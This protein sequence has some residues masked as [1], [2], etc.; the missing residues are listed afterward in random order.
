MNL[1]LISL[2]ADPTVPAGLGEGG[3]TH[4]YVRELLTY[5]SN[6]NINVLLITRKCQIELPICE[7]IA[8]NCVIH[9]IIL[10]GEQPINKKEL[11]YLHRETLIRIQEVLRNNSFE[12]DV[13][14]SIYWNSGHVAY[15]LSD[16]LGVPFV[17]S[18][19]SNGLRRINVGMKEDI[20]ERFSVEKIIFEKAKYIISIT[21]SEKNDLVKLYGIDPQK[22]VISGRPISDE[23]IYQ[24]HN[25]FGIPYLYD[26]NSHS[27]DN[28]D[29]IML[30]NIFSA[31]PLNNNWW[32]QKSFI[33]CGRIAQ[34]KG[35]DV[36]INSW[37]LLKEWF[38]KNCPS[39][40]IVGGTLQEI[41]TFK[42]NHD[43]NTKLKKYE[44]NNELV[45]WGYLD[46][47]GIS[48]LFLKSC[49]LIMHSSYEPGG[50]V[51]TEAL[52]AGIPVI[53]AP[54]G[55]GA[56]HVHK[57]YNGFQVQYGDIQL[58]CD[59]MSL[60]VKQPYL[61]NCLGLN[62]KEYMRKVVKEWDFYELHFNVYKAVI[63]KD[64][65]YKGRSFNRIKSNTKHMNYINIYPYF[66]EII[67]KNDLYSLLCSKY[68]SIDCLNERK[69][70]LST[71]IWT[72]RCNKTIYEVQQPYTSLS[73]Y[74]LY[75]PIIDGLVECRSDIFEREKYTSNLEGVN[76]VIFSFDS[77]YL[78]VKKRLKRLQQKD[79]NHKET[80]VRLQNLF[81]IFMNNKNNNKDIKLN[82]IVKSCNYHTLKNIYQDYKSK[83]PNYYC[84]SFPYSLDFAINQLS[85]IINSGYNH[86]SK[87]ISDLFSKCK[88]L[89]YEIAQSYE[90]IYGPC[91]AESSI[92]NIG[93][94]EDN[95]QLCF[96]QGNSLY[97]GD[98]TRMIS[99]FL[100]DYSIHMPI[101]DYDVAYKSIFPLSQTLVNE[102]LCFGWLIEI[103]FEN[104]VLAHIKM[105]K[106]KYSKSLKLLTNL[107]KKKL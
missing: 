29:S 67:S 98:L 46:Q 74:V 60:F 32:I 100:F 3:G 19:I 49:A 70:N 62:A 71:A 104:L 42:Q 50:R 51:V 59:I 22:I 16:K 12:P 1:L 61:S 88:V 102:E 2:H 15:K 79:L 99:N 11:F 106:N 31:K 55:F 105:D 25:D 86:L 56:D 66:N 18:V 68:K 95:N 45:W 48:T 24:A 10:N 57:W 77:Y 5:L 4:S 91:L 64:A 33:Y 13:I 73:T 38:P 39:L 36:I 47:K 17:H 84:T 65:L 83:V 21:Q 27:I 96:L 53:S 90:P 41:D 87:K 93:I 54:N 58:L 82:T 78:L 34:N 75:N 35:V 85:V 37:L 8:F 43:F 97:Y 94:N 30:S 76:K 69:T 9:R 107:I 23:L 103:C 52:S 81:Q 20:I 72:F 26:I 63:D 101:Q 44:D 14:H 92:K 6:K 80:I 89:L 28:K 40:W 7:S